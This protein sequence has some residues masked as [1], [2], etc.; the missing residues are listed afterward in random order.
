VQLQK[1][2][3]AMAAELIDVLN[4]AALVGSCERDLAQTMVSA[5]NVLLR[6]NAGRA[7]DAWRRMLGVTPRREV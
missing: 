6:R 4:C 2:L 7:E 5:C 3:A 1:K